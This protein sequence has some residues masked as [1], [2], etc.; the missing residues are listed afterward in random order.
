LGG[1]DLLPALVAAV[2]LDLS[3]TRAA[4]PAPVLG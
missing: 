3:R 4:R 1:T 2:P